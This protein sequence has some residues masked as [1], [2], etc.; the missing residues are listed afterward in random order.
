MELTEW[1]KQALKYLKESQWWKLLCNELD[2]RIAD[3]EE[4]LRTPWAFDKFW[5][6]IKQLNA[7]KAKQFEIAYLIQLKELPDDLLSMEIMPI[8]K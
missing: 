3:I 7:I 2:E 1:N 6:E 8:D 5:D 4:A